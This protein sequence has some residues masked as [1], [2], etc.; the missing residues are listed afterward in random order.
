MPSK[1]QQ[2]QWIREDLATYQGYV[3]QDKAD[4]L[5]HQHALGVVKGLQL[6]LRSLGATE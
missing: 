1:K 4:G 5:N 2:I 6:A 3:E